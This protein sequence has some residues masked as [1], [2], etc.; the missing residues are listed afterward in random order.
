MF[1]RHEISNHFKDPAKVIGQDGKNFLLEMTAF[2]S[3]FHQLV[4]F[5]S[6]RSSENPQ[7]EYKTLQKLVT[8]HDA[9]NG[10]NSKHENNALDHENE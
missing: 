9:D 7:N 2:M 4:F 8:L 10:K 3:E 6:E 5:S 1:C